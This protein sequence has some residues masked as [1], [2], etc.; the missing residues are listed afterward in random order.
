[1]DVYPNHAVIHCYSVIRLCLGVSQKFV[2]SNH[3]V[4][5]YVQ[6]VWHIV[7]SFHFVLT[8]KQSG[9][10]LY[11]YTVYNTIPAVCKNLNFKFYYYMKLLTP[12]AHRRRTPTLPLKH[13]CLLDPQNTNNVE[14]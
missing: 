7:R 3:E 8:S 6:G 1:M 2:D 13:F 9:N 12:M 14:S 5:V 4:F 11:M 10:R